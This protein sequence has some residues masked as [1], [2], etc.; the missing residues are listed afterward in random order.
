MQ[1]GVEGVR[2]VEG[3]SPRRREPLAK[4]FSTAAAAAEVKLASSSGIH[5]M[6]SWCTINTS[7]WGLGAQ[8][9]EH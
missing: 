6:L 9:T 3:G 4:V 8:C 2:E 7:C 5:Y 1:E